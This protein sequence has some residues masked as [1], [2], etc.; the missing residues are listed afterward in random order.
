MA[1][2]IAHLAACCAPSA[3]GAPE[4]QPLR[5]LSYVRL[6]LD[7]R[8]DGER[9]GVSWLNCHERTRAP[10]FLAG[11]E[12]PTRWGTHNLLVTYA[13]DALRSGH[14]GTRSWRSVPI[15][16]AGGPGRQRGSGEMGLEIFL[17]ARFVRVGDA[18]NVPILTFVEVPGVLPAKG[19][20]IG[21]PVGRS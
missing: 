18:F 9:S 7:F 13:P 21:A 1:R 15:G 5:I 12:G 19:S 10:R 14:L 6:I 16:A 8:F 2:M 20:T 3:Y 11:S 17:R 4:A